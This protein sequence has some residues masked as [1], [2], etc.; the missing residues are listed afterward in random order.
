M[1]VLS[2]QFYLTKIEHRKLYI[3]AVFI[4]SNLTVLSDRFY[5]TRIEHRKLYI[6]A[7]FIGSNLTVL[8]DQVFA[9]RQTLIVIYLHIV[10]KSH[11]TTVI[12]KECCD[13]TIIYSS[14]SLWL[15]SVW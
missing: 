5:I 4:G 15:F 13:T 10:P 14:K 6:K 2:D 9:M 12:T 7:V 11:R 1:T 3:K 8:P